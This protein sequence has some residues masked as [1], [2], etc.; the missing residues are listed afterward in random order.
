MSTST[1]FRGTAQQCVDL[2]L[3][4]LYLKGCSVFSSN[5]QKLYKLIFYAVIPFTA[6][7][8][9]LKRYT[10]PQLDIPMPTLIQVEGILAHVVNCDLISNNNKTVIKF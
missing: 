1:Q 8:E 6:A 4:D 7:P 2:S 5:K 3:L 9:P 10:I